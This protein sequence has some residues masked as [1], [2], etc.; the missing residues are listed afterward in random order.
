VSASRS[1]PTRRRSAA[2]IRELRDAIYDLVAAEEPMTVRQVF[3]RLVSAGLIA[4]TEA[5]YK[6]T[7]CRLLAKMRLEGELPFYWIADNTRWTRKPASYDGVKDILAITAQAYRRALWTRQPVYVEVWLEKEALAGVLYDVTAAWDV[8]LMVTRGYAS[9]S[10]LHAAAETIEAMDKP[11][12]LYFFGDLDP[13]GVDI[14]RNVEERLL[15]FAPE[16][17]VTLVRAA[18]TPEQVDAWNLPTRP[19]KRTDSRARG[20]QGGS[21]EV[22]AIPPRQLRSLA[23]GYIEHHVDHGLLERIKRTEAE[24]R[25]LLERVVQTGRE[26][27]DDEGLGDDL[28]DEGDE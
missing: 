13:S 15:E 12:F 17:E 7:V 14:T 16:A 24:E 25:R 3:Y 18:V 9:L 28:N 6:Q 19:T 8:P 4:K 5:E 26:L 21:V 27:A 10:F 20:W 23:E 11:T 2:D 22:D 1:R